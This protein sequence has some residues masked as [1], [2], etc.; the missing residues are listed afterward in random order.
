MPSDVLI[1]PASSKIEFSDSNNATKTL[2]ITGT[3]FSFDSDLGIGITNPTEQSNYRFLQVNGTNSAVIE[4]M[5]GGTRIG[6]FDSTSNTL[7]VGTIGS[8]PIVFRTAVDEKWRIASTGI[9]QSNG[10]QTIQT[11]TGNLTLATAAGNGHIILSNHGTGN[12][13]I[14]TTSPS[15]KLHIY[16]ANQYIQGTQGFNAATNYTSFSRLIFNNDYSNTTNRGPNKITLYDDGSSWI[17]GFGIH[18]DITGYYTGGNHVWYKTTSQTASTEYM[19]ITSAGNVGIGTT[20]PIAK[21]HV[22]SS[23]TAIGGIFNGRLLVGTT[24]GVGQDFVSIR[25][26]SGGSFSQ[27]INIVDSN[28]SANNASYLVLR[29]SDDTYIGNIRRSSTDNAIYVGGNSYLTLGSGDTER[30]RITA[31]GN[32][33][34]GTASP[35]YKLDV[36]GAI[37]AVV[38]NNFG[39]TLQ[40]SATNAWCG[41]GYL[42]GGSSKWFVGLREVGD[43]NLR[44][45]NYTN[46][47]ERMVLTE[48]GNLGIGTASASYVLDVRGNVGSEPYSVGFF[49]NTNTSTAFGGIIVNGDNQAHIRFLTGASTWGA[50]GAKQWQIRTGQA[51]NVDALSIYSWTTGTDV[52]YINNAGN[53]GI[54]T[55]TPTARIDTLG[56][57]LGRNF[58]LADRATVRLD[59]NGTSFPSDV[60]FGHTSAANQDGW[61]GVYWSLSSRA[62]A[63]SNRFY[64]YRGSGNPAPNNSEAVIMSFDP[65]LNVGVGFEAP[66]NR[67][68]I[69]G[70][71]SIG[72]GY[73]T[74]APTNGLIVQGSVGI[75]VTNPNSILTTV[76]DGSVNNFSG[77]LRVVDTST[78]GKWASI[79][80]PD[81]QATTT[82]ANNYYLIGR[83]SAYADRVLSF[84]IPNATDYGSGSQPRFGF[85]STGGV[86]LHS[87]EAV[88]GTSYFLGNVGIGTNSPNSLLQVHGANPFVRIN[89]TSTSSDHGIKI[90]YNNSDTWGLH[91][92]HNA[93]FATSFIDATYPVTSGQPYGDIYFRQ[94]IGGT[95]TTRM[96]I[97]A[98][99][100][101]VGIGTSTLFARFVV[102]NGSSE[103]I[104]FTPGNVTV[105]GGLIESLNRNSATTRPDL[106]FLTSGSSN[107]SIKFFTNGVNER[108]RV[109]GDGNVGIGSSSPAAKLDVVDSGTAFVSRDA[110]GYPR[111]TVTNGSAQLGLFRSGTSAGGF[112]IGGDASL[113]SV[114]D[115]SFIRLVTINTSGN[116]GIGS[117][118]PGYKLDVNGLAASNNGFLSRGAFG[119]MSGVSGALIDYDSGNTR[120][121][122]NTAAGNSSISFLIGNSSAFSN[123]MVINSSGN[124]GIGISSPAFKLDV[125]GSFGLNAGSNDGNWPFIVVDTSSSGGTNRY[126]LNKVGAM[127]FN[128]PDNYAQ[129]QLVGASGAYIDFCNSGT[130]D[131]D[132]RVI[133]FSNS[134]LQ[135]E[136]G[137]TMMI[138]STGVGIGTSAPGYLFAVN[139]GSDVWHAQF[140]QVGGNQFRIGGNTTNGAVIGA[141]SD[142]TNN[143]PRQLLLNRDGG[144]VGVGVSNAL[145]RLHVNGNGYFNSTLQVNSNITL[146]GGG[147]VII[148][149]SDGTGFFASFM[150]S[151]VG[152]I[153]I[154]DGGTANGTLNINSGA[155]FVGPSSGNV[156]VGNTTPN[157]KLYV[158]GSVSIGSGYN[159]AAPTNGLIVQ[160]SF[161]AGTTSPDLKVHIDAANA[162]PASSGTTPNGYLILRAKTAGGTH[163]MYLGVGNASPFGSWIQCSDSGNL[164]TNYPLLLNPNGGN[165]GIGLTNPIYK[166]HVSGEI[167]SST[168][169]NAA[170]YFQTNTGQI[171][172][173]TSMALLTTGGSAQ[174]VSIRGILLGTSYDTTPN[175]N[176]IRTT[177]NTSLF[178]NARGTGDIQFQTADSLK[179]ML[180]NNGNVGI[181]TATPAYRLDVNGTFN[182]SGTS[183]LAAVSISGTINSSATEAI[184]VN[185]NNGF[186]SFYNSA[187]ATRT[188]YVQG[189]TGSSLTLSAENGAVLQFLVGGSERARIDTSGRLGI[190]TTSALGELDVYD[191]ANA[192]AISYYRN[193]NSGSSAYIALLLGNDQGSNKLVMFTNSSTRTA[194]GGAGNSTIRT[195]SG[196]LLLGAGGSQHILTTT[197]NVGIGNTSPAALLNVRASAPTSTGTVTT[198]TNVLID[199]NTSNYITFR[200]TA[201]NGTYAGLV[202]L[203]NNIGG[204][205]AFRNFTGDGVI[206]G[207]DCMIY[208]SYQDHIFQNGYVNENLYNR[209]ETMRIK[210]SGNVGIGSNSPNNRLHVNGS[211]SIGSGY[212]TAAPTNGLIVEGSVG[213]GVTSPSSKLH[214]WNGTVQVSGFQSIAAGPLTFLRSDYNGSAAV[215]IN[216]LNINPSNGYDSDLGIQ[217]MNVG[218]SM[219]DVMRIKGSTGNVGIGTITPSARLHVNS[220]TSGATLLRADGTN[221]T[222]FSVVDDLSDSLMSV[223]N[224]AGLPVLEVFADDRVVAGQYG[225]NDFVLINNK[226]GLGINNPLNRL[227]VSG[228]M[229]V[230]DS[231]YNVA[232]PTNGLIVQGNVG[233]GVTSNLQPLGV[234]SSA[235]NTLGLLRTGVLAVGGNVG[236]SINFYLAQNATT[237]LTGDA[238]L[239]RIT[240]NPIDAWGGRILFLTKNADGVPGNAPT[241][242]MRLTEAGNLGIGTTAPAALLQVGTGSPTAFASGIQFGDD[243]GARIF[244]ASS[245]VVGVSNSF[246][247]LNGYVYASNYLQTGNNLIYP[248]GFGSTQRLEVGNAAQN[249]WITG[250]SIAPGGNVVVAG[251]LTESSSI[252][253]KENIQTISAPI[254]PK[255]EAIRPVTYNKKDNP[256]NTEYGIIAEE[257]NELFPELVNKNDNGE[258]ESVNYSRLTV[259]LIKAVKELKQEIEILKNK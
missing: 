39:L 151:G 88:T 155:L 178:L 42:T 55:I 136:Y 242:K 7:F 103:N 243:T 123:A 152:Y 252:R 169:I 119:G 135:F 46:S 18:D 92:I 225:A 231:T 43:D 133:Y 167:Y 205:I 12:V 202:F 143:N 54:G 142:N 26:D 131:F 105:N 56:V 62:A 160:G 1:T 217:L 79:G 209:T 49:R 214:V 255:L 130:D 206:A 5:V 116:L 166:F 216:F 76:S 194:D 234:G 147:D 239:A 90:S 240:V 164:A 196:N 245:A 144:N 249:A 228:S 257:L 59:A 69:S 126:A 115:T 174:G 235:A 31:D 212:N 106:N 253:Y 117:S 157:N 179:M 41:L 158:A 223:N 156:G 11:S 16:N 86:L 2:R 222:L 15:Q 95:M 175:A 94:N 170:T 128:Y 146:S 232:A 185:N 71:V 84:H 187:G 224:S 256:N 165:V 23:S 38:D 85:Y 254:L 258:V 188:G 184:R 110:N 162:Y 4:T 30:M 19:R 237:S 127:G 201:D 44:W 198:G 81:A 58:S 102:S 141:Y 113:F 50:V 200:N 28:S 100:G 226:L 163:G 99:G 227:V 150:D 118:S 13:G 77:V 25:Y 238:N 52:L 173:D 125:S 47:S 6:G 51:A 63:N 191:N 139:N 78:I 154:D 33:G 74:A 121:I 96:T 14:G 168:Y 248:A 97:K 193:V 138:N 140:G 21:L 98:D 195:D 259:L 177:N 70:S 182:A 211:T 65:N 24:T 129:L 32:V 153:R 53:V 171:R 148:N 8:F 108:M 9:L 180:L 213:I 60:L 218:G 134:R 176:E 82:A 87:I 149:D 230:G 199:S 203:D 197:G 192:G 145:Y 109:S 114:W 251:T 244:R 75:G 29:K 221:G 233:M 204:Y 186:I 73:N 66:T 22:S 159:T 122:S 40:R 83:A 104:E 208:G 93:N 64:F 10:A 210:A 37:R 111:F 27:S 89:N 236:P 17:G 45:Y 57:R 247:A 67:L 250:I 36:F 132:A 161:G 241:E 91:L 183:T 72:S 68:S 229:S 35:A 48:A 112:Y 61:N 80:L 20:I 246:S 124:V 181:N 219:V 120:I 220:T 34:I 101:N 107:G 3:S 215:Q 137:T 190:G 189:L 207:S 172:S